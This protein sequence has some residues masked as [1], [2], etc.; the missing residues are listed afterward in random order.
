FLINKASGKVLDVRGGKT[1]SEGARL[2]LAKI[3]F[4]N[5][6]RQLWRSDEDGCLV[7]MESNLVIDVAGGKLEPNSNI[8]QWHEKLIRRTRKNQHWGLSV[9]GHIHTETRPSLV[10]APS[11]DEAKDGIE[12]VLKPRGVL[13]ALYQQW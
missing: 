1:T 13:S 8:I 12:L 4:K 7:N 5:Y 10:I 3:D 9:E 11:K 2:I 6:K